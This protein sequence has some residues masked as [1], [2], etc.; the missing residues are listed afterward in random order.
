MQPRLF[1]RTSST[2]FST[3]EQQHALPAPASCGLAIRNRILVMPMSR[4]LLILLAS[5]PVLAGPVWGDSGQKKATAADA[6]PLNLS[7]PRDVLAQS[8]GS[9][10]VDETVQRNLG[11]PAPAGTVPGGASHPPSLPYGT[12]Y[13][14]RHQETWGTS[15]TGPAA[16]TGYGT[17]A[18]SGGGSGSGPGP[19][20]GHGRGAGRGK[21]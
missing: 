4:R 17:G 7:L 12:G 13:E 19:D 9:R 20:A 11:A 14:H 8:F 2:A 6:R 18:S 21:R 3:A 1:R 16:G 10:P 15:G 5:A